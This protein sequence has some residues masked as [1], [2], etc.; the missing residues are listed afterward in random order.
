MKH[1]VLNM[2]HFDT[3]RR[4]KDLQHEIDMLLRKM[5][6]LNA[7]DLHMSHMQNISLRIDGEII[8][9]KKKINGRDIAGLIIPILESETKQRMFYEEKYVDFSY[10]LD[11]IR[12]RGNM[13]FEK[14]QPSCVIR[15]IDAKIMSFKELGLPELLKPYLL[16]TMGLILVTGPTGSGKTTT[17]TSMIDF[18]NENKAVH[19]ATI[20]DPIEYVHQNK[21]AIITQ[22]EIGRDSHSFAEATRTVLR[23]DPDVILIG[24]MRDYETISAA[25]TNAETGHLVLGTLHTNNA[26]Q[27]IQR[28]VDFFPPEIQHNT[29]KRI[30]DNLKFVINQRLFKNKS[31]KGRYAKHEILI[32]NEKIRN[33][34]RENQDHKIHDEMLKARDIGNVVQN[35]S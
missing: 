30:A 35:F 6:E 3:N 19:I 8:K 7:S 17:L 18:I 20:E 22:R 24:E 33:L 32:P 23:R 34:I 29:R 31:G 4:C 14:G 2:K 12:F 9:L 25:I 16:E 13:V 1:F 11:G 26:P 28:M 10:S 5:I 21:K 15:K 27:S